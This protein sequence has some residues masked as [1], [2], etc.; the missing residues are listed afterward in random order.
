MRG[1]VM[2]RTKNFKKASKTNDSWVPRIILCPLLCSIPK[3]ENCCHLFWLS[4]MS[5]QSTLICERLHQF[6]FWTS[7]DFHQKLR[8]ILYTFYNKKA[9][10]PTP[11]IPQE[12]VNTS[13]D[14]FPNFSHFGWWEWYGSCG[15]EPLLLAQHFFPYSETKK[16]KKYQISSLSDPI[17]GLTLGLINISL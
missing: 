1:V 13:T 15:S 5:V 8:C 7:L 12:R 17:C 2:D 10:P 16:Q 9:P 3:T 14:P 4:S 11:H 6:Q